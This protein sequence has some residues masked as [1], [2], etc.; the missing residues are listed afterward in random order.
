[1]G[2]WWATVSRE[3]WPNHPQF[4]EQ[5]KKQWDDAWGDRRQELVF[6]G[7]DMDEAGIRSALDAC[8]ASANPN[9]WS[10]LEDPFPA[11]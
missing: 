9:E 3:D 7:V 8:L 2:Y 10:Q 5:M 1:M 4:E 6:I 11:W